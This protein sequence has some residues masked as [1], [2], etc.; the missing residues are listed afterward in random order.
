M[1]AAWYIP[2]ETIRE[3]VDGNHYMPGEGIS[4]CLEEDLADV[5]MFGGTGVDIDFVVRITD[6]YPDIEAGLRKRKRAGEVRPTHPYF[7]QSEDGTVRSVHVLDYSKFSASDIV[8]MKDRG[9]RFRVVTKTE[10]PRQRRNLGR[11]VRPAVRGR[12]NG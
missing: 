1:I 11:D 3:C 4:C 8:K 6:E 5:L 2:P 9:T 7:D 10:A 12:A